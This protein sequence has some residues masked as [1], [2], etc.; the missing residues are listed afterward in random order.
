MADRSLFDARIET[1]QPQ[2]DIRVADAF[3]K[4]M[5]TAIRA[6]AVEFSGR[7]LKGG[8]SFFAGRPAE[9]LAR[10]RRNAGEGGAMGSAAGFAMTMDDRAEF[11]VD[12]I[13]NA[14]AQAVTGQ[15][16]QSP[17]IESRAEPWCL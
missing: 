10:D 14:A 8:K 17:G 4:K 3:G 6:K 11:R 16:W 12:F 13:S 5:R 9:F 15:Q 2:H 1:S 7:G